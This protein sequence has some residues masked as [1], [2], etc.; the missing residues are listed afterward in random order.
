MLDWLL[1]VI[2]FGVWAGVFCL[3]RIALATE[4]L[5]KSMGGLRY[6]IEQLQ[7]RG[8]R[9]SS[10]LHAIKTD[11]SRFSKHL[12]EQR[13]TETIMALAAAVGAADRDKPEAP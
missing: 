3:G 4:S 8:E 7:D 11:T 13:T 2:A 1:G 10:D 6:Q 5:S 9:V 12:D